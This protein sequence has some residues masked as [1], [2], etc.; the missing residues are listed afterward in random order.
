MASPKTLIRNE[1][2]KLSP[3]QFSVS[4]PETTDYNC[5]AHA[6]GESDRFWWPFGP[7]HYYWPPAVPRELT[8]ASFIAAYATIGYE[9][10]TSFKAEKGFEKVVIYTDQQGIPTHAARLLDDAKW[11]S[12]LG[13]SFDIEHKTLG[14]L[15]GTLYGDPKQPLRRPKP[16]S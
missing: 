4:S 2:P 6:A 11:S 9:P 14:G 3:T 10:C 7:P 8:L 1:F 16:P 15:S 13:E 5:I 12:K